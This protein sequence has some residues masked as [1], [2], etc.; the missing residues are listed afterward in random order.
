MDFRILGP[1]EIWQ[2]DVR[3]EP[4]PSPRARQVLAVLLLDA[5]H[6]VPTD[7]IVEAVW[8]DDPPPN[9][10]KCLQVYVSQLRRILPDGALRHSP[11]GYLLDVPPERADVHVFR[12]RVAEARRAESPAT[13]AELLREALGLWRGEPLADVAS[14]W[15]RQRVVPV[16]VEERLS[17]LEERVDADLALGRHEELAGELRRLVAGHPLRERLRGQLM[18]ALRRCG[19]R[20]EALQVFQE[21]RAVMVE[22]LGVEPGPELRRLH[23]EI[24][25]DETPVPRPSSGGRARRNDLP[26]DVPDFTGRDQEL[27][28]IVSDVETAGAALRVWCVHGR[29][30]VGKTAFAVH[31][32]RHLAAR[33]PDG[34][35]FVELH[36]S[37]SDQRPTSP[38]SA[39]DTVLR[40]V[41][42]AAERVPETVADR[43]ALWRAELAGRR[44]L[45]VLDDAADAAQVRPLLPG[46]DGCLVLVTSRRRLSGLEGARRLR[47]D[48]LPTDDALA[49][50]ARLLDDG[51]VE[52]ERDAAAE[53]VE[54]CER[55]PLAIRI[56]GAR[57]AARSHWP[58]SKLVARLRC[59]QQRLDELAVGDLAVRT[60]LGLTYLAL[61]EPSRRA[62]RLLG[63]LGHAN[64]AGWLAAPLLDLPEPAAE[65]IVERLLDAQLVE[66]TSTPTE[67]VRYRVHDLVRLHARE[68]AEREEAEA[69]RK[70]ALG[71]V[72]DAWM[73]RVERL[74]EHLPP[75][76]PRL[77]Q[78]ELNSMPG[79]ARPRPPEVDAWFEQE[80]P[81]LVAA[82]ERAAELGMAEPAARLAEAL[83]FAWFAVR[84]RHDAWERTHNAALAAVRRS[85]NRDSEAALA[86]GLGQLAYKRDQLR[87]A[88]DHFQTA[89]E[90]FR[91]TGNRRGEAVALNGL[92]MVS[93]ELADHAGALPALTRAHQLLRG[94]GDVEG[95]AHALYGIGYVRRELGQDRAAL[96]ALT[97]AV[98]AYE[99]A[100]N[101]R[102]KALALR[103]VGLVYRA[104]DEWDQAERHFRLAHEIVRE[105]GDTL[106]TCYTTQALA[107]TRIRQGRG[108]EFVPA[109]LDC[110]G[111]CRD[112]H[113]RFG[114]A[115]IRRTLGEHHLAAGEL[116]LARDQLNLSLLSWSSLGLPLWRARTL[117]D[118]GASYALEGDP[119]AAHAAW[120]EA[121]VV[122]RR[123][124]TR[125]AAEVAGWH[126]RWNCPC[127]DEDPV[128]S[129]EQRRVASA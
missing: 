36:G 29:P 68:R 1:V 28:R 53:V 84:N 95:T 40:A 10:R 44:V 4:L 14:D 72:V 86:C 50:F 106:L 17:A 23:E 65:E 56:T 92:G 96:Q 49:L 108:D 123:L 32:A 6:V 3:L 127:R 107:K 35:L 70:A 21:A 128:E 43:A 51:R 80:E 5:G 71:R 119:L 125:E 20:A 69:D 27:A 73:S 63:T 67:P 109:L 45:V 9:A 113:D 122:F 121:A 22:E 81:S 115:L 93:R 103:G 76:L 129:D 111:V 79:Q 26:R 61:D 110:L 39:L 16:L 126:A 66:V 91:Q 105:V 8:A 112:L 37:S 11:P 46:G 85:G 74:V 52:S 104:N 78:V 116:A 120:D 99:E 15:V 97:A 41:G 82:V 54:L 124:G 31:A 89:L 75:A 48:V 38:E 62:Y 12:S 7:R 58:V 90:L 57:L 87:P 18:T 2:A 100:G 88:R 34:Q 64:V 98:R 25:R 60:G 94:L 114:I 117:R 13:A 24:L 33:Y 77:C 42:V 30:G 55:L 19:R 101:Q 83:V 102:G 47:L 59:E 118:L